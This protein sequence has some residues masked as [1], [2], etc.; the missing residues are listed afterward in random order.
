M[1]VYESL[2]VSQECTDQ[3]RTRSSKKLNLQNGPDKTN[4]YFKISDQ[5]GPD[6]KE[7]NFENSLIGLRRSNSF[8]GSPREWYEFRGVRYSEEI[9]RF[10]Y[11]KYLDPAFW[12]VSVKF[13]S[14]LSQIRDK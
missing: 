4:K 7:N 10:D 3:N 5:S 11:P 9:E 14:H 1:I 13:R 8:D 12:Q 6:Q 2:T